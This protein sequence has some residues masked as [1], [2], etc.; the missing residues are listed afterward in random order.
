MYDLHTDC[1]TIILVSNLKNRPSTM[2]TQ[3]SIYWCLLHV[4]M[5]MLVY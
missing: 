1:F 3:I 2:L 5:P 4:I